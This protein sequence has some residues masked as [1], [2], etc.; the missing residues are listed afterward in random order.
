[1]KGICKILHIVIV[2]KQTKMEMTNINRVLARVESSTTKKFITT[3]KLTDI[4]KAKID[5]SLSVSTGT[6]SL[7]FVRL[8]D[9]GVALPFYVGMFEF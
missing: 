7:E 6:V 3:A 9:M 5:F 4:R 1:M 2:T 8:C